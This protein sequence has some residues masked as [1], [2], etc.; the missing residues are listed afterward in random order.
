MTNKTD[1]DIE[2]LAIKHFGAKKLLAYQGGYVEG[3]LVESKQLEAFANELTKPQEA[4]KVGSIFN[5]W[6][7]FVENVIKGNNYFRTGEYYEILE[8]I[9][10][11]YTAPPNYE[12]LVKENEQLRE[13]LNLF[14]NNSTI[15]TNHPVECET[16]EALAKDK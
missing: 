13:A 9:D 7:E 8:Y 1:K 6:R 16:A 4:N 5:P 15:Q 12:A 14:L 2:A 3:H 11:L 10:N